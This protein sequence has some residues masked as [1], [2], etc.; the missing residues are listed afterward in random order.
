[1]DLDNCCSA[2]TV[3]RYFL[4]LE[5]PLLNVT[6]YHSRVVQHLFKAHLCLISF[7]TGLQRCKIHHV[8]SP[9]SAVAVTINSNI[10]KSFSE[11][12]YTYSL[13]N[14]TKYSKCGGQ[15]SHLSLE[16]KEHYHTVTHGTVLTVICQVCFG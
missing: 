13:A 10:H 3:L 9:A 15:K 12:I 11:R 14:W 1:M 2:A 5:Q 4:V 8:N 7:A 16:D 6:L